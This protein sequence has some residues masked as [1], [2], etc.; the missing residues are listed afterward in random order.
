MAPRAQFVLM[1]F[2][3][4]SYIDEYTREILPRRH[5]ED[6]VHN[7]LSYFNNHVWTIFPIE[8]ALAGKPQKQ[9]SR[10]VGL[11]AVRPATAIHVAARAVQH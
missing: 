1:R 3:K 4:D 5:I 10:R 2:F 11:C 8:H 7:E 9:P 6:A